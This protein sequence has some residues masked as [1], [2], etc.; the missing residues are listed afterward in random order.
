MNTLLF[1]L[2]LAKYTP[3]PSGVVIDHTMPDDDDEDEVKLVN[4]SIARRRMN[5]MRVLAAVKDGYD[6]V[7]MIAKEAKLSDQTTRNIL[8]DLHLQGMITKDSR[9]KRGSPNRYLPV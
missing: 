8:H 1:S 9:Y 7:W 3:P 6:L 5:A 4:G 2:G